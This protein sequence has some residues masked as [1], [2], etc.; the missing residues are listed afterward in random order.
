M[1]FLCL[2][3][4]LLVICVGLRSLRL[5]TWVTA[6]FGPVSLWRHMSSRLAKLA[7]QVQILHQD[8]Q[9]LV[10]LDSQKHPWND[11]VIMIHS[12]YVNNIYL[13]NI[14]ICVCVCMYVYI[15][16]CV[17]VCVDY[18][19]MTWWY[20]LI[21]AVSPPCAAECQ[22]GN[23]RSFYHRCNRHWW[24]FHKRLTMDRSIHRGPWRLR[25]GKLRAGDQ[26]IAGL[27]CRRLAHHSLRQSKAMNIV[28]SSTHNSTHNSHKC[29]LELDWYGLVS[30]TSLT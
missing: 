14:Y 18:I 26:D 8:L 27:S 13:Y 30:L 21:Y 11:P 12:A 25:Q 3:V 9:M 1:V 15:Y 4:S 6:Q 10:A 24:S 17:C 22:V 28:T 5:I 29:G 7:A 16:I 23:R 19:Y 20:A 2:L